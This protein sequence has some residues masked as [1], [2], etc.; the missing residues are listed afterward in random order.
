MD[1]AEEAQFH[2][3]VRGVWAHARELCLWRARSLLLGLRTGTKS[4]SRPLLRIDLN[5]I[6]LT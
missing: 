2:A 1:E 5:A 3:G 6:Q 4:I